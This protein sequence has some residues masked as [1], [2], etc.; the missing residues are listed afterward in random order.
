[1]KQETQK[2]MPEL[3]AL[4]A[5]DEPVL[6][7][8]LN[9]MLSD[10]WSDLNIV[11]MAAT[12]DEAWQLIETVRPQVVFLDIKMPG[13]TGLEVAERMQL[14][15]LTRDCA[16]VFLTAYD[17]Y[18][19]N[20]FEREAVDY[21]LKPI[22]DARLE[23]TRDR[24]LVRFEQPVS[25]QVDLTELKQLL[26]APGSDNGP[27]RWLNAQRGDDIYVIDVDSVL[28]FS[29][30]D[31]YTTVVTG[32]GE[33]LIRKSLKQLETE[34]NGQQFWRIHR[35]T[36]VQVAR[37]ERVERTFSGHLRVHLK[38]GRKSLSVSRRFSD[39]FKQM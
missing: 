32:E 35:S 9:Q 26:S 30:E 4:I 10:M 12:G 20:A 6:R 28:Y 14:A 39:R 16:V 5:D 31:K 18:A 11:A 13:M 33:Y 24:I 34:L 8:H 22:D 3:T 29:A 37:I 25:A 17:E 21:L 36:L 38:G 23:R 19:V 2:L 27:L 1:V 7:Y 15:G